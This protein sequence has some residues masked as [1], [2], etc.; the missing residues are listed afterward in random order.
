[1][2]ILFPIALIARPILFCLGWS[3]ISENAL[4][5]MSKYNRSVAVFSHTS[6]IDFYLFLL[7]FLAYPRRLNH[8]RT[9]MKPQP[10][11]YAGWLLRR[12]G[13]VPATRVDEKNGG[14]VSRIV[15]DL[16]Q[17]DKC[18]LLI[19]PKGTIVKQEWRSG[20]YH[21]A[22][23]LDA[24]LLVVGLDYEHK[25]PA[26]SEPI[27]HKETESEV[28]DLL[29]NDL[30]KIVPL[31]PEDEIVPIRTHT[32]RSVINSTRLACSI[33]VIVIALYFFN[34]MIVL[35]SAIVVGNIL[36]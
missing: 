20:Y 28:R 17:W 31:F 7:Y 16:K 4:N 13:A 34:P 35:S 8:I 26:A 3:H 2:F 18:M 6:Y 24:H 14:A 36:F 25:Y 11:Q 30:K 9:L 27:F 29:F 10:F 5:R 23:Q 15:R 12:F 19:S 22:K 21:I 32:H 1:M 33:G